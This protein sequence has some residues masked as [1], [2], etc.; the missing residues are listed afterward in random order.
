MKYRD[1]ACELTRLI[2]KNVLNRERRSTVQLSKRTPF[3]CRGSQSILIP[4]IQDI[5]MTPPRYAPPFIVRGMPK[6]WLV[7][8]LGTSYISV[9]DLS[10]RLCVYDVSRQKQPLIGRTCRLLRKELLAVYYCYNTFAVAIGVKEHLVFTAP[11][12]WLD[13]LDASLAKCIHSIAF[14]NPHIG[15][16]CRSSFPNKARCLSLYASVRSGRLTI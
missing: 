11:N 7:R 9:R 13:V 10:R 4:A 6:S 8:N 3:E 16:T 14:A 5:H 2:S 1:L 12:R 15:V